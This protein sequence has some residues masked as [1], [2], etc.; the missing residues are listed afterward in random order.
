[1]SNTLMKLVHYVFTVSFLDV[2]SRNPWAIIV[3][4]FTLYI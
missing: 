4:Q 3:G 1:M 2:H